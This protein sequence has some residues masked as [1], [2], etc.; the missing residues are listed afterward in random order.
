[1]D[2]ERYERELAER[3]RKHLE[4]VRQGV[5]WQPCLHDGCE[6]CHGTGVKIDG[7]PCVHV[8]SC[9]CPKCTPRM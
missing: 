3:K 6:Q 1:M 9:P 8:I 2:R 7:T 5:A 4:Q